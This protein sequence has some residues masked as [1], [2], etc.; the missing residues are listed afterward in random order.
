MLKPFFSLG[1]KQTS[2][3]LSSFSEACGN[4]DFSTREKKTCSDPYLQHAWVSVCIDILTRNVARAEYE[5]SKNGKVL[6]DHPVSKLFRYPN[7]QLSRF[8]L[9]KQ[10]C[11]WWSLDGE[12][13]WWFGDDYSCGV[14]KELFILNPRRMQ[15]VVENGKVIKW[16]Y[17]DEHSGR[18]TIIL[19]DEIIHFK[20]WNPWNEYRG[21]SP[22]VSLGLEVEQDLLAARQN[23]GLLKEGGVPKGLLKTDQVLT[24]NEAEMLARTWDKKYGHGMKNRVAV[25]GKGTEYQPLTFSPDVL[26]LYDMKKWNL[27]T[28]LAKYGIPPRIANIQ[29]SKSSLSGTDTDSQQRAFWN[30]TLIPLLKNF[31]QILEVQFYRR[32]NLEFTGSFNLE[33]IPELQESEDAQSNRDIAEINAGLKTINDVLRS[34]GEKEKPWGDKWYRQSSLVCEN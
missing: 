18:P 5:V 28:I 11:A 12:A 22:L 23:T 21:V 19:P 31:E 20:D 16:V 2:K 14:P 32:F 30:F 8:D 25:L 33:M 24:E 1:K 17:T 29:D 9:W 13:F 27:Y 3:K 6:N 34:R 26:K 4:D 7:S 15:H 10:T